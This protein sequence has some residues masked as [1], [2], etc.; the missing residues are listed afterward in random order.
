MPQ[1]T[2]AERS[3]YVE[4]LDDL[5]KR[6]GNLDHETIKNLIALLQDVRRD[7]SDVLSSGP[8]DFEAAR[9]SQLRASVDAIVSRFEA[10]LAPSLAQ[11]LTAGHDIGAASVIEPLVSAGA[12]S[13]FNTIAPAVLNIAD[14][15]SAELV[16]GIGDDT[17]QS[18]NSALRR[19]A[20]GQESLSQAMERVKQALGVN[21]KDGIWGR[22]NRP[23]VVK[24]VAARAEAI[25]RTEMTRL[26]NVGHDSQQRIL[27][28]KVPGLKK[29]WQARGDSRTRRAHLGTHRRTFSKPIPINQKFRVGNAKLRFPG[30]PRG[31]AEQTINCRC[32]VLTVH[33]EIG[34]IPTPADETAQ[35]GVGYIR[36]SERSCGSS[37]TR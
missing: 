33:P 4:S 1:P 34:V 12:T 31:P 16:R 5:S 3:A 17:R 20:L 6:F 23:E 37:S 13:V 14:E 35:P 18:I 10:Q 19:A 7:M 2:A 29:R 22:R 11:S 27:A 15:F 36:P 21:P 8:S 9:V 28:D 24:G 26:H 30:D 25:V 32:R